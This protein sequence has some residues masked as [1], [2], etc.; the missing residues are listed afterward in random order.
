MERL[1]EIIAALTQRVEVLEQ[2]NEHLR[3]AAQGT[4]APVA[5]ATTSRRRL[6][7]GGAG[8]LGVLAGA[9]FL[10]HTSPAGAAAEAARAAGTVR[11]SQ[12]AK[13]K[14]VALQTAVPVQHS[15]GAHWARYEWDLAEHFSG[16]LPPVVVASAVDDFQGTTAPA[17]PTCAV[18]V[19]EEGGRYRAAILLGNLSHLAGEATLNALA[20]GQ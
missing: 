15:G 6:L 5:G 19:H 8:L 13:P 20:F 14:I 1:E 12:L 10:E 3:R 16:A 7:T 2:E 17:I 4:P 18:S 9:G 11:S